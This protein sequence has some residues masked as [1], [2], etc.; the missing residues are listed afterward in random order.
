MTKTF[1]NADE[2]N[3]LYESIKK[4]GATIEREYNHEKTLCIYFSYLARME[5]DYGNSFEDFA[6]NCEQLANSILKDPYIFQSIEGYEDDADCKAFADSIVGC[7]DRITEN[8]HEKI[9]EMS[10]A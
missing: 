3:F 2:Y 9:G 5:V 8:V 1:P 6:Y 4:A 7:L 10:V